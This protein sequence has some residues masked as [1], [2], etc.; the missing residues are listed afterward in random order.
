MSTAL[1]TVVSLLVGLALAGLL[2]SSSLMAAAERL[3]LGPSREAAIALAQPVVRASVAIGFHEPRA[4][5]ERW[6]RPWFSSSEPIRLEWKRRGR[7]RSEEAIATAPPLKSPAVPSPDSTEPEAPEEVP[8]VPWEPAAVRPDAPVTIWYVGDSLLQYVESSL[9]LELREPTLF[10]ADFDWRYSTGLAR[11]DFFNW[12]EHIQKRLEAEQPG[13]IVVMLGANDGQAISFDGKILFV[14]TE[15]WEQEYRARAKTLV[16]VMGSRG[17]Q[18]FW[19]GLPVM[20]SKGMHRR[21][22]TMNDAFKT[23]TEALESAH[24]VD[25]WSLFADEEGGYASHLND[26]EGLRR[27]MRGNDG[28]HMSRSGTRRLARELDSAF[29]EIWDLE[30]WK[31]PRPDDACPSETPLVESNIP[32]EPVIESAP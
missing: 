13:A 22:A 19:I 15:E 12:P 18:V 27:K 14:E 6:V 8:C 9:R 31:Q 3:E 28:V 5:G 2:N 30:A 23:A 25:I 26:P 7:S 29:A 10:E 24:Y 11:P 21:A 20:R 32:A 16:E 1:R 4:W 17:A